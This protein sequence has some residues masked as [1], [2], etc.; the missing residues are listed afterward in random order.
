MTTWEP[1]LRVVRAANVEA[2]AAPGGYLAGAIGQ[3]SWSVP[4]PRRTP[5]PGQAM[6]VED[7]QDEWDAVQRVRDVLAAEGLDRIAFVVERTALHLITFGPA[8]EHGLGAHPGALILDEDAVPAPWRRLPEPVPGVTAAPSADPALLEHTLRERL[9]EAVGATEEEI[10][11][12]EARLGVALPAELKA[13]YRV[14]RGRWADFD[15]DYEAM[16]AAGEALGVELY[17]LDG[18]RVMS[19]AARPAPW[20]AAAMTA[21]RTPPGAA[22]QG[23]AGSPG[24]IAFAG[25]GGGDEFTIDLTPGPGGHLG[26]VIMLDHEQYAGAGLVADSLTDLIVHGRKRPDAFGRADEAPLVAYVNA[27]SVRSVEAA[28][29]PDLEVLSIGVWEEAPVSLAPVLG[30]PRL[31]TLSAYPGTLADPREIGSLTDLEYLELGPAEWRTLLDAGAVPGGLAAAEI[32]V[33]GERHPFT[34][35]DL[36]NELLALRDRPLITRVTLE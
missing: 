23:L 30:L 29:H 12:A 8:V 27:R 34:T 9:P 22:V 21:V 32:V 1:L 15:G 25:N 13:I 2:L 20:S 5:P 10:A 35:M 28:A 31:R 18:L 14:I 33:H 4:V 3:G 17:P 26:Q 16:A 36:A 24:W 11:E 6:Q 7:M 19:A